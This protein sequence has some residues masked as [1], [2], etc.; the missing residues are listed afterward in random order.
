MKECI[1]KAYSYDDLPILC[2]TKELARL[3][4]GINQC[5]KMM[6]S[7]DFPL[8]PLGRVLK[9]EKT[10]LI[11]YLKRNNLYSEKEGLK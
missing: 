6:R 7:K 11:N 10:A 2:G 4:I 9:V 8:L 5:R 3:G 1:E